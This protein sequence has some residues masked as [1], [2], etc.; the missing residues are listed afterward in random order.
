MG[1]GTVACRHGT[2]AQEA[3]DG[4]RLCALNFIFSWL[5][6]GSFLMG[7]VS[8]V[9]HC[10]SRNNNNNNNIECIVTLACNSSTPSHNNIALYS[11]IWGI[12]IVHIASERESGNPL[13]GQHPNHTVVLEKV[14]ETS[15]KAAYA[16]SNCTGAMRRLEKSSS[17]KGGPENSFVVI[18]ADRLPA[19]YGLPC[20]HNTHEAQAS[21]VKPTIVRDPTSTSRTQ[22]P[23]P[24]LFS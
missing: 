20:I 18:V 14:G 12:M 24:L 23:L 9:A 1:L 16:R 8:L 21:L 2:F 10:S 13:R 22:T 15:Q 4:P 11:Y 3:N 5:S 6:V 7:L 17:S 19:G